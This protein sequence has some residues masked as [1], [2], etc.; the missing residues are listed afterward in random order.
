MTRSYGVD[1]AIAKVPHNL[2]MI[3]VYNLI[4]QNGDVNVEDTIAH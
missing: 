1:S 2:K 4:E 3:S